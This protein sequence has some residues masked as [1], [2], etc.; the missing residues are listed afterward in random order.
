MMLPA[1]PCDEPRRIDAMRAEAIAECERCR[2]RECEDC[3]GSACRF[4]AATATE[5]EKRE[6]GLLASP[7][8]LAKYAGYHRLA[9]R[10]L[11]QK[12]RIAKRKAG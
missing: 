8:A 12:R 3:G 6:A 4:W 1:H 7:V 9:M 2:G 5:A 10:A 11:R